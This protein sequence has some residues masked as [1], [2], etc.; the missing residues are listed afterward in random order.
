VEHP[1]GA[2]FGR[3]VARWAG[4]SL[5]PGFGRG[6]RQAF[7]AFPGFVNG[8]HIGGKI[9]VWAIVSSGHIKSKRVVSATQKLRTKRLAFQFAFS[10]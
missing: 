1:C 7:G 3:D 4:G 6:L 10:D 5:F 2:G 8:L 9:V